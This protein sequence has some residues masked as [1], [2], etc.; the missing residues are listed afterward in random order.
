MNLARTSSW[1]QGFDFRSKH[2][3]PTHNFVVPRFHS[4]ICLLKLCKRTSEISQVHGFMIKTGIDQDPFATS[5]LLASSIQDLKYAA[6]IFN[7]TQN[8]NLFMYNTLLRG[9]SIGDNPKQAFAVFKNLRA[10]R[11]ELDQ[12]SFITIL[13]ASARE[14]A[15]KAGQGIHGIVARSGY[16]MF[17]N[18]KNTL[19]HLYS[20]CGLIGDAQKLFDEFSQLN[21]LVSWNALMGAYLHVSQPAMTI[22]VYGHMFRYG[23]I[24]S[25][26]TS[27]S[28]LSAFADLGDP[29]GG[30]TI[31]AC[32][33]KIGFCSN[34]N[35][36][37]AL[38][39]MYAKTGGI[40]SGRRIF[41]G[42]V[43]KDV[44]LWNC[45]IDKYAK[46]GL[47]EQAIA[48]LQL[49]KLEGV[50]ANSSSLAGLLA[51]CAASGSIKLGWRLSDYVEAEE[52]E[53]DAVLGTALVDMFGKCGFLDKAIQVFERM[54]SKD[55]K[56]WTAMILGYGV[57]GQ[58]RN[59]VALFYRME[60]E[61]FIPNEVTF[62]GVL[63]A[64]SHGGLV[65]EAMKCFERMVQ[66]YGISPKI[67]HYGCMI[68]LLGRLGLLEEAHDLIKRLPIRSDA[69]AWRALLAACRVYGN[70]ELG[71]YANRV[72]VEIDDQ[73]PTDSIL[74][75]NTY[76][77]AGRS[78]DHSRWREGEEE[79]ICA[80]N[81]NRSVGKTGRTMKETG[82]SSIDIDSYWLEHS[83]DKNVL[84]QRLFLYTKCVNWLP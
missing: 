35:V 69:T 8:P 24:M 36:V 42:I 45:M 9:F 14:L 22:E 18:V 52:L 82:R 57:H 38:I 46:V 62:L 17:V 84:G 49:M 58:A 61:G 70:V 60:K 25:V 40:D 32:C 6:S 73:H 26:A 5:K 34:L 71:E 4:L 28:V 37:T 56:S 7:H 41:D 72:L 3:D 15:V 47:L 1:R 55:V 39:E 75:S 54:E 23:F 50:R 10:Q 13:K 29:T 51:A 81:G 80:N 76:A 20:V 30:E 74:L 68:D 33:I 19:L 21:D 77:I 63:S 78:T 83:W 64:C 59:A 2:H 44:I 67:E 31:H 65:V 27:L 48:L 79:R 66:V 16:L 11:I 43:E 53:V 12:F